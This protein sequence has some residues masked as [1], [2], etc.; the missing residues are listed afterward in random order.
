MFREVLNRISTAILG[1]TLQTASKIPFF[2]NWMGSMFAG[3][4]WFGSLSRM[5]AIDREY[6]RWAMGLGDIRVSSIFQ[7]GRRWASLGLASARLYLVKLDLDNQET[8]ITR[9]ACLDRL[10]RPNPFC[11]WT[12][13]V[14]A[15]A[16]NWL[17]K[18]THYVRKVRDLSISGHPV[19][20]LWPEPF[21]K[22]RPVVKP[23]IGG[24]FDEYISGYEVERN[25]RWYPVAPEDMIAFADG[26]DPETREGVWW[27]RAI[28]PE[29]YTDK[30]V[31]NHIARMVENG[32]LPP[33]VLGIGDK[34]NAPSPDQI[35]VIQQFL[36]FKMRAGESNV[37][38]VSGNVSK[39]AL[40][41][42]YSAE[43]LIKLRQTPEQR[44]AAGMGVS[45]ISLLFGAGV[46]VSTYSN[47]E[48]Y[49]RRDYRN[50]VVPVHKTI[51]EILTQELL[52]EFGPIQQVNGKRLMLAFDYAQVPEMQRDRAEDT[53]WCSTMYLDGAMKHR[54]YRE[55]MGYPGGEDKYKWEI[56]QATA[57][58]TSVANSAPAVA[59]QS[60]MILS[61]TGQWSRIAV[62]A[63]VDGSDNLPLIPAET[64]AEPLRVM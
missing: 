9:H 29:L 49:M 55:Q 24:S 38:A 27:M 19:I 6:S 46:E 50:W 63:S 32:L 41:L 22:V 39:A 37:L 4:G 62:A 35:K 58:G 40:Q 14:E 18:G 26:F 10:E 3:S 52:I 54:E 42:D 53:K 28:I 44:F 15:F 56:D 45:V 34:K 59:G 64:E 31:G 8:E 11:T 61:G 47:V 1:R 13:F 17:A 43:A 25:G 21:W 23:G 12:Q 33:L 60:R 5:P 7:A 51:A 20:E 36:D 57:D 48:Q 30:R 16:F 2:A